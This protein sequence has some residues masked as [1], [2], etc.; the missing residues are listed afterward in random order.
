MIDHLSKKIAGV[1]SN[2]KEQCI[3]EHMVKFKGHSGRK[4]YIKSTPI[5]W[6]FKF[7]FRCCSKTRYLYQMDIYLGKKEN[8]EF[9]LGEEVVMQLTKDLEGSLCAVYF[10]NFF[11][12]PILIEKLF[13]KNVYTIGTDCKNRKQI[14]KMFED[15]KAKSGDWKSLYSKNVMARKCMDDWSVLLISTAIEGMA[16]VLPV[17]RRVKGSATKSA[18]PCP[19]VVKLYNNGMGRVD[20]M[21]QRNAAYWLDWKPSASFY[22]C[23]LFDLFDIDCVNSFLVYNMKNLKQLTLPNYKIVLPKNFIRWQQS[24]QRPVL[25]SR[26]S[27]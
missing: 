18:I 12:S 11:Y 1:L 5:K 10:D 8:T 25:L 13:N 14:P 4:Q 21:D 3:H 7:W 17:Q 27:K 19:T 20:L 26:P 23:I 15:K 6:G 16:N 2:I 22:L 9:N 24:Y